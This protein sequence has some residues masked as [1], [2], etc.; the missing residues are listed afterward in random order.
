MSPPRCHQHL[1][2]TRFLPVSC[3]LAILLWICFVVV[4]LSNQTNACILLLN[5]WEAAP[6]R[7]RVDLAEV[8]VSGRVEAA[9]KLNRTKSG[10]YSADVRILTVYKG[11]D[12]LK[13]VSKTLSQTSNLN[14]TY[15]ISNFGEQISCYADVDSGKKYI[16]FLTVY[17]GHLSGK[18]DD[19]FGAADKFSEELDAKI[20]KILGWQSWSAWSSCRRN[21]DG[22]IQVRKRRCFNSTSSNCK[23]VMKDFRHCNTFPCEGVNNLLKLFRINNA[24]NQK[25]NSKKPSRLFTVIPGKSSQRQLSTLFPSGFPHDFSLFVTAKFSSNSNGYVLALT[26]S[27]NKVLLGIWFGTKLLR[28]EHRELTSHSTETETAIFHVDLLN[29]RWHQFSL[30]LKGNSVTLYFDC[31][32]EHSHTL[33]RS[34]RAYVGNNLTLSIGANVTCKNSSFEWNRS[35]ILARFLFSYFISFLLISNLFP[36]HNT[37]LESSMINDDATSKVSLT[38]RQVITTTEHNFL[39]SLPAK[40]EQ[41]VADKCPTLCFNGGKCIATRTN[42]T[43]CLC[44][45][46]YFGDRCQNASCSP[47]C[48]NGGECVEVGKCRCLDGYQGELCEQAICEFPCKNGGQCVRPNLC[49]CTSNYSGMDCSHPL[50]DRGCSHGGVCVAANLCSCRQ[51]YTGRYCD[52]P[53]CS[54]RC[55]NGGTCIFPQ[56][57]KCLPNTSGLFCEKFVGRIENPFKQCELVNIKTL[58]RIS[59]FE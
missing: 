54:R 30:S 49:K 7:E 24:K 8:V 44:P 9:Y 29:Q 28:I 27:S 31:T 2:F 5:G 26:D 40:K 33:I 15:L 14:S 38:D 59:G 4:C 17:E 46:R 18:Y 1:K 57:C 10:T 51:G 50:C 53:I 22:G 43:V 39:P 55:Q 47:G 13:N 21:C 34:R 45:E 20:M 12:Y 37:E 23:G 11:E 16:F 36:P 48:F 58:K 35:P 52:T 25:I 41:S 6:L 42:S 3:H 19:I 32:H 56:Q